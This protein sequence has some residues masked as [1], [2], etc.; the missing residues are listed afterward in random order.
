MKAFYALAAWT[1]ILMIGLGLGL[2]WGWPGFLIPVGAFLV[3]AAVS[4]LKE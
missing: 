1:G 2:I 3:I 4:L